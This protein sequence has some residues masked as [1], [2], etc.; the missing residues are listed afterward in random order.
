M[1][2]THVVKLHEQVYNY[3]IIMK[4]YTERTCRRRTY[5]YM[6]FIIL[7]YIELLMHETQ[8]QILFYIN[9]NISLSYRALR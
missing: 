1:N 2:V 6:L 5:L 9:I 3:D 7:L 8:T 4:V